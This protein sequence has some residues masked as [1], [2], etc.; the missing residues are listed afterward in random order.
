[1]IKKMMLLA[2]SAAA[3]VAFAVPATASA[4]GPLI[5]NVL[6]EAAS[7]VSAVSTNT[8]TEGE[9]GTRLE[10]TTVNL[11]VALS[12]NEATTAHGS[13]SGSAEGDPGTLTHTG[14]CATSILGVTADIT[15]V[16][17]STVHLENNGT[18]TSGTASFSFSYNLVTHGGFVIGQCVFTGTGN[19][20]SPSS[21]QLDVEATLNS[22]SGAPCPPAGTLTGTFDVYD[23]LG[24]PAVIH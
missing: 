15:N 13:G 23:E 24:E 2:V 21:S 4:E 20:T 1:M 19:V 5:T 11:Q 17:V 18:G 9:S 7:E 14:N 6:G 12:A 3:V 8:V 22:S 10:C 16:T